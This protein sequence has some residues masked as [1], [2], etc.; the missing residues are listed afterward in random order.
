MIPSSFSSSYFLALL[1]VFDMQ[2]LTVGREIQV[3][4]STTFISLSPPGDVEGNSGVLVF[5]QLLKSSALAAGTGFPY[6][7]LRAR[8]VFPRHHDW[9]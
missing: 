8:A 9:S 1:E 5:R 3:Q 2:I 6:G 4:L 7:P